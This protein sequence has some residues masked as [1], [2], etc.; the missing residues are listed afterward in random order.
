[1]SVSRAVVGLL[2]SAALGVT[3]AA[4]GG[5]GDGGARTPTQPE[6]REALLWVD[7]PAGAAFSGFDLALTYN[8]AALSLPGSLDDAAQAAG[9]GVGATCQPALA[10]STV[11]LA[12]VDDAV[13]RGPGRVARFKL[14][15]A[16]AVPDFDAFALTC[17]FA[18]ANGNA[19]PVSC[20]AELVY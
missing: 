7:V 1:M 9:I 4:C 18:D 16:S 2:A 17:S 6:Q 19:V 13:I 10:G 11:R 15:F 5:G 3:L 8:P 20:T 14:L 12:C